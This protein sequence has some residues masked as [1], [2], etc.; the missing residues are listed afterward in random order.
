MSSEYL[1]TDTQR[2]ENWHTDLKHRHASAK[3]EVQHARTLHL[4]RVG[5]INAAEAEVIRLSAP[6]AQVERL[7]ER[8]RTGCP[9]C[10]KRE[11]EDVIDLGEDG[12]SW[13]ELSD[14]PA[15]GTILGHDNIS[16]RLPVNGQDSYAQAVSTRF[17]DAF[18]LCTT[19]ETSSD[20]GEPEKPFK[21][22]LFGPIQSVF[23]EAEPIFL[24]ASWE[25]R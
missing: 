1:Y 18:E 21:P 22:Y 4:D 3:H 23:A 15:P 9:Y 12:C 17:F 19:W 11:F 20:D 24:V 14:V 5:P 6:I 25:E 10:D 13:Q 7:I 2:L 16:V 8:V